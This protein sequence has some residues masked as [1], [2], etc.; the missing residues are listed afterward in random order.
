M[1]TVSQDPVDELLHDVVMKFQN[2][3][4]RQYTELE[5]VLRKLGKKI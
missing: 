1:F 2:I 5:E 4:S 3:S